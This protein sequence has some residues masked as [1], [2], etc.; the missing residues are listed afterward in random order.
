MAAMRYLIVNF[1]YGFIGWDTDMQE[2][3]AVSLGA[4]PALKLNDLR[5][6][7]AAFENVLGSIRPI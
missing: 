7:G 2:T 6:S 1:V 5:G 4:V 3:I